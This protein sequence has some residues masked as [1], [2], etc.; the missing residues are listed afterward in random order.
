MNTYQIVEY[1]PNDYNNVLKDFEEAICY[2][3]LKYSLSHLA[4][5]ENISEDDSL[6]ALQKALQICQLAGIESKYHFKK[7]YIYDDTIHALQMDWRMSQ[8]GFNLMVMQFP[9]LN[10]KKALWLWELASL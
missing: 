5:I 8:K 2:A 9:S 7:I 3:T 10:E 6:K 4:F 1:H